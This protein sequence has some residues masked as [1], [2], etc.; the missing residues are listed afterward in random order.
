M[1]TTSGIHGRVL[2]LTPEIVTIE[3]SAGKI[4][5]ERNAISNELTYR[6]YGSNT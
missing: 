1:V 4:R 5:F 3:T 2:E 6:R